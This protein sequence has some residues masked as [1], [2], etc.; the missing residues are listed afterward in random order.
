[1]EKMTRLTWIIACF[2]IITLIAVGASYGANPAAIWLFDDGKGN[3]AKDSSGNGNDGEVIGAKW[4]KEGK[5][6]GA[7][8][9]NGAGNWVKVKDS[10]SLTPPNITL[11]AWFYLYQVSAER[12]ICEKYDWVAGKGSYV[13][14]TGN[15]GGGTEKDVKFMLVVG[16]AVPNLISAP[17]ILESNK[18]FHAAGTVDGKKVRLYVNGGLKEEKAETSKVLDSDADLSIG[19]RGDTHDVHWVNGII[20]EVAIFDEAMTEEE[21]KKVM[22]LGIEGYLAVTPK[23]KITSTWAMLKASLD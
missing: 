16:A 9:F 23:G 10:P 1:M 7:L 19:T 13:L 3:V 17:N 22:E 15:W 11:M 2:L 21:I 8:E 12:A 18:W 6:K 20:D 14:R 5:F 4:I